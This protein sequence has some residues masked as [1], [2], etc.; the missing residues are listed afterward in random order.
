MLIVSTCLAQASGNGPN[1]SEATVSGF[2]EI[3]AL[4]EIAVTH[5]ESKEIVFSTVDEY[6]NGITSRGFANIK[7]RSNTPW[8]VSVMTDQSFST[9]S[10][11]GIPASAFSLKETSKSRFM[12]LSNTPQTLLISNNNSIE[13][14]Y[15]IDMKLT[16][17]FGL[18]GGL[19]SAN[20]I[21]TL[22]QQ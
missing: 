22:S 6:N 18:Y 2:I 17:R 12:P 1:F 14:N 15:S 4:M 10:N 3:P 16:P 21:I 5:A 7:I 8:V 11:I 13:N 9:N 19:Y 20:L